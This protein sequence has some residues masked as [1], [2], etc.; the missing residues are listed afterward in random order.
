[1][2]QVIASALHAIAVQFQDKPVY[3]QN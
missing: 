3:Q 2:H 1:M